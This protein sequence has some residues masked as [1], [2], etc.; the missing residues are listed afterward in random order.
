LNIAPFLPTLCVG[1]RKAMGLSS[2]LFALRKT[3][4]PV[5]ENE[6]LLPPWFSP[7]LR[8]PLMIGS[9]SPPFPSYG[10]SNAQMAPSMTP[11]P[12][13]EDPFSSLVYTLSLRTSARTNLLFLLKPFFTVAKFLF[14]SSPRKSLHLNFPPSSFFQGSNFFLSSRRVF[15]SLTLGCCFLILSSSPEASCILPISDLGE[16]AL[17]S[18][19]QFSPLPENTPFCVPEHNASHF[20]ASP[21]NLF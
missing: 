5:P 12:S 10:L 1:A 13:E 21:P 4:I 16:V 14:P 3:H 15:L 11:P 20:R 9:I 17:L 7:K 6:P 18:S 8:S 19:F 2:A